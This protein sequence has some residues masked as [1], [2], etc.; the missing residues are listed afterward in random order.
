MLTHSRLADNSANARC[1]EANLSMR[2][3]DNGL[4]NMPRIAGSMIE[5]LVERSILG[6]VRI[7]EAQVSKI[8]DEVF[9]LTWFDAEP[10]ENTAIGGSPIAVVEQGD[11]P[12]GAERL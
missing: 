5:E 12:F 4:A 7:P 1:V 6:L 11:V 8:R 10:R 2:A 3:P 9:L